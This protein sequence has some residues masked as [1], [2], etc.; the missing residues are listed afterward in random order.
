MH[1]AST[2]DKNSFLTLTYDNEHLPSTESLDVTHWQAFAKRCRKRLGPFR[3]YH[4]GEYGDRT[5]RMH[6]HA[7]IFG[8]DFSSDRKLFKT[9]KAGPLYTSVT[10]TELWQNG[11]CTIGDLTFDSAAYVARYVMKKITGPPKDAHYE[12]VDKS[13]GEVIAIK[14]EYATM[15]RNPGIGAAWIKKY[16]H[17]VYPADSV[18][19]RGHEATPPKFYDRMLKKLDP[20]LYEQ[21]ISAR[22]TKAQAHLEDQT[23]DRLETREIC[24]KAKTATLK[25]NIE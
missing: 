3:F 14:P 15:S 12:G 7:C 13:T 17:E 25:R 19:V 2:H 21:V 6:L 8:L 24:S 9:T 11:H 4:C 5:G 20:K 22:V 16:L 23:P 1:E 18:I 10:L